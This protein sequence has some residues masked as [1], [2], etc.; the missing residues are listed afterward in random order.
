M[1]GALFAVASFVP[2][3]IDYCCSSLTQT[4]FGVR[5]LLI[6]IGPGKD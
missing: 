4:A 6:D 3:Q 1:R 2:A 5:K